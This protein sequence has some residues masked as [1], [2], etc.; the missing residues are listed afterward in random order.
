MRPFLTHGTHI[1]VSKYGDAITHY[2]KLLLFKAISR[3]LKDV[4]PTR[5][6]AVL[7]SDWMEDADPEFEWAPERPHRARNVSRQEWALLTER[8]AAHV[9]SL[10]DARLDQCGH[11]LQN[12]G[13]MVGLNAAEVAILRL[14]FPRRS[15]TG[16]RPTWMRFRPEKA[17]FR[18]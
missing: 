10:L 5:K 7:V 12:L 17:A 9:N 2:Q 6:A 8:V 14:A 18:G 15:F 13:D 3:V 1:T 16:S 11:V 4:P